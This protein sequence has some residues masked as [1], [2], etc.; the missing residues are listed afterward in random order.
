MIAVILGVAVR[1][2]FAL[3]ARVEHLE[4]IGACRVEQPEPGLGTA[5]IRDDQ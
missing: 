3:V 5:D 4:R 2:P 1:E